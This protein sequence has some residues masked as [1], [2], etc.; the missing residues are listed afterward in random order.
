MPSPFEDMTMVVPT[1]AFILDTSHILQFMSSVM[2]STYKVLPVYLKA[3]YG[4]LY[5]LYTCSDCLGGIALGSSKL[6]H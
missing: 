3:S 5:Y 6:F 2:Y 1:V 4:V